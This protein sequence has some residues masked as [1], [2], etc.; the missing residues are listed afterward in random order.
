[1]KTAIMASA[2][3][4]LLTATTA[5]AVVT[6]H[7]ANPTSNLANWTAAV[8]SVV[9][10][11]DFDSPAVNATLSYTGGA[12]LSSGTGPAQ[13]NIFSGPLSS[14]E[15]PHPASNYLFVSS[16]GSSSPQTVTETFTVPVAAVGV[17]VIDYF[18]AGGFNN[19][20]DIAV[21]SGPAG[22][23]TLLGSATS[24]QFNFQNNNVYFMGFTSTSANIG[25]FV[26]SRLRDD[27]G[28]TIGLD[29]FV[30]SG[31]AGGGT[32]PE[33][34]AWVMMIAGFGLVGVA[35]RRRSVALA[36]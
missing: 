13:G 5:T 32:V 11:I 24:V 31:L 6:P 7:V 25:S 33:P 3:V 22:T 1:M 19:F 21:Y 4:L 34:A 15:G 18:G 28:D 12:S 10:N 16:P 17:S 2:F 26:F 8:G 30:S 29:N 20:L 23:G 14:G 9:T 36:A 27:T 35:A